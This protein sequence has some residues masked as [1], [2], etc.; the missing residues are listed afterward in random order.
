MGDYRKLRFYHRARALSIRVSRL[1]ASLPHAE[2][3]RRG[4]QL[5]RAASSIRNN[6]VE[7]SSGSNRE[8]A[9]F[10]SSSIKSSDE[11]Q[12]QLQ[13]L[14]DVGLLRSEDAELLGEPADIAA[15]ITDF[16]KKILRS[17]DQR[18]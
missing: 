11:V 1:V 12:E 6:I 10:L 16:R 15:M 4:D 3:W 13:E 9:R 8:F 14:S 5:I 17:G 7:G 2:Q 18:W